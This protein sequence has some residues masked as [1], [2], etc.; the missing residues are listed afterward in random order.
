[1]RVSTE[2]P[3]LTRHLA[4]AHILNL[5]CS[6][7]ITLFFRQLIKGLLYHIP[8]HLS[9]SPRPLAPFPVPAGSLRGSVAHHHHCRQDRITDMFTG[10]FLRKRS[11]MRLSVTLYS[12]AVIFRIRSRSLKPTVSCRKTS[13][14]IS[15]GSTLAGTLF[16][17]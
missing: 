6:E 8:Y 4:E 12:H 1:M 10:F 5:I 2:M 16:L 9:V 14:R 15:S 3:V 11:V 7:G 17:I 13:C